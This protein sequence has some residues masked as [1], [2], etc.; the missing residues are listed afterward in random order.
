MRK[1]MAKSVRALNTGRPLD[2]RLYGGQARLHHT[3]N[4]SEI[5]A[6]LS[7]KRYAREEY[8]FSWILA[9]MQACSACSSPH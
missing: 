3:G 1:L 4:N 8:A 5:K 7:P 9:A 2:V 6:L